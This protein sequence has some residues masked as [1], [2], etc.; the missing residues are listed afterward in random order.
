MGKKEANSVVKVD[1][2]LLE[3]IDRFI[4]KDENKFKFVSKKHFVDIAIF[5]YLKN[6]EKKGVKHE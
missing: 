5:E 1:S 6:L 3:K 4:S 2:S